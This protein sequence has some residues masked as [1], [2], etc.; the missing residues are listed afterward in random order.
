MLT[1]RIVARMLMLSLLVMLV[2]VLA[3]MIILIVRISILAVAVVIVVLTTTA[4]IGHLCSWRTYGSEDQLF[5]HKICQPCVS[6]KLL[7]H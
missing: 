7:T 2:I 5:Y 1:I 6:F 3:I 4:W